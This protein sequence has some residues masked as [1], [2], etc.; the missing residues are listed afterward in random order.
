MESGRDA[1]YRLRLAEGFLREAEQDCELERWRSAVDNSQ[2]AV[3]NAAKAVL[4][5][6][7]PVSRVHNPAHLLRQAV[8]EG[9]FEGGMAEDVEA[10]ATYAELLG[11]DVHVQ[12]D[13]GDEIGGRTPWEIFDSADAQQSLEMARRGA[14]LARRL[15]GAGEESVEAP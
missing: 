2:L 14:E 3:E 11:P 6:V 12:T 9:R 13:Y 15:V 5:L 8:D 7:M 1:H 4:S 10:L